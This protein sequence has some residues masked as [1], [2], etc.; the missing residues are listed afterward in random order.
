MIK[1]NNFDNVQALGGFTPL[2][3]GGHLLVIKQI[4]ETKSGNGRDMIRIFLDTQAADK[5]P[6]YYQNQFDNDKRE[7]KR[8]GCIVY[9]TTTDASGDASRGFKTFIES[10]EKSNNGFKVSWDEHFC[11]SLKGKLVG[12]VFG[13]EEYINNNG[14]SKFVPKCFNFRTIEDIK[15]GVEA[16]KDRLLNGSTNNNTGDLTPINDGGDLPF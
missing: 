9:Q 5:Q 14:E 2:E 6:N 3:V 7:K 12:G 1:P 13:R 8:W 10:V 4:Q 15:T 11:S 16:P